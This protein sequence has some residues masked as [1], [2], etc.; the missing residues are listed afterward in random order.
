MHIYAGHGCQYEPGREASSQ[1]HAHVHPI[2]T[3]RSR[4]TNAKRSSNLTSI[5]ITFVSKLQVCSLPSPSILNEK[6]TCTKVTIVDTGMDLVFDELSCVEWFILIGRAAMEGTVARTRPTPAWEAPTSPWP[7]S[8]PRVPSPKRP[9]TTP[10]M[11]GSPG[12]EPRPPPPLP[13]WTQTSRP[14]SHLHSQ[15]A[16][17]EGGRPRRNSRSGY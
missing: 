17:Q 5:W 12:P 14:L 3:P 8:A 9:P 2:T 1:T 11:P 7:P 6:S 16:R 15:S 4:F 10:T 13:G